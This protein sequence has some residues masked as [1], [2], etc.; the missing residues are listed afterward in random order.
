MTLA[1][2]PEHVE[3]GEWLAHQGEYPIGA[4]ANRDFCN[5]ANQYIVVEQYRLLESMIQIVRAVDERTRMAI[6]NQQ[7]CP[8]MSAAG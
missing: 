6:C 3:L 1:A 7:T 4:E 2:K 5:R 8:T